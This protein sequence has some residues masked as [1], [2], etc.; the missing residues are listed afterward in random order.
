M[1]IETLGAGY[2]Q[3]PR[4]STQTVTAGHVHG[5]PPGPK[6]SI[7]RLHGHMQH[8]LMIKGRAPSASA[9]ECRY[10][11]DATVSSLGKSSAA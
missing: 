7:G 4:P 1:V 2:A 10:G 6:I 5:Q 3:T 11:A 9:V 8:D